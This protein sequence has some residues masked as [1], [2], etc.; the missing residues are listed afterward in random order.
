MFWPF[1]MVIF[2]S[3]TFEY[4]KHVGA[5]DIYRTQNL[6]KK[7]KIYNYNSMYPAKNCS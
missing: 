6:K 4:K 7:I 1:M 3:F 2:K 5:F